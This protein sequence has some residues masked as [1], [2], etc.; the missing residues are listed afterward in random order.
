MRKPTR[1]CSL[2]CVQISCTFERSIGASNSMM[3]GWVCWLPAC[4]RFWCFLTMLTCSTTTRLFLGS[5]RRTCPCCPLSL[6]AMTFTVSPF[7]I[8]CMSYFLRP[9]A[10]QL[11]CFGRERYNF[12][13]AS[14]A[15]FAGHR[16]K[17]TSPA[18]VLPV[19]FE[20]HR[21][22]VVKADIRA[23]ITAIFLDGPHNYGPYNI[24]FLDHTLRHSLLDC[25]DHHLANRAVAA[26]PAAH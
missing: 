14:F 26:F 24:T 20:D 4:W 25:R 17:N 1:V 10:A 11:K 18:R 5:T 2:H 3:P 23:V 9:R 15:Q 7:F 8:R 12:G 21:R 19:R 22:I 13:I 6:P 16:A